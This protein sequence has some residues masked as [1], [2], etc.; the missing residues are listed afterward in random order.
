[1]S[2]ISS[3]RKEQS[4]YQRAY[5]RVGCWTRFKRTVTYVAKTGVDVCLSCSLSAVQKV[6]AR[7]G[8][9]LCT[10]VLQNNTAKKEM[11]AQPIEEDNPRLLERLSSNASTLGLR[12]R[13]RLEWQ[14]SDHRAVHS[15][16]ETESHSLNS[17]CTLT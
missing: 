12:K 1:M 5:E 6:V 14:G 15:P 3:L 2:A 11:T 10:T 4:T 13:I 9:F 16:V 8:T 7:T 17:Q